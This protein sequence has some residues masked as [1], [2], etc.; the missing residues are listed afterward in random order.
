MHALR[1][2]GGSWYLY[3]VASG[4]DGMSAFLNINLSAPQQIFVPPIFVPPKERRVN[5]L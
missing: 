5:A 2:F 4:F 1:R 3:E